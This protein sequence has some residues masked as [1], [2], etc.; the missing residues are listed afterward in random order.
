MKRNTY[1]TTGNLERGNNPIPNLQILDARAQR[2]NHATK[3]VA[4]DIALLHLDD[5]AMQQ[6]Q[7]TSAHRASRDFQDDIPVLHDT[8]FWNLLCIA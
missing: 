8:G 3:L 1:F 4:E 6:M 7:V 2:L 5:R